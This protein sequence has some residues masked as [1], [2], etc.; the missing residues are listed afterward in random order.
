MGFIPEASRRLRDIRENELE[1][2]EPMNFHTRQ[3]LIEL[4]E[5]LANEGDDSKFRKERDR[6]RCGIDWG[7]T[8]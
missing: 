5:D 4:E 1:N 2:G 7:C 6:G 3:H 8:K